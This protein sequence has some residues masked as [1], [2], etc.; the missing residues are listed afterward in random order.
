MQGRLMR[1]AAML[2]VG[3]LA[4]SCMTYDPYTEE[5]KVSNATWGTAIGAAGGAA[6]GAAIGAISGDNKK[7]RRKR[8]LIGAG[9]GA[10]TGG[11]AGGAVGYYMDRQEAQL[12]QRLRGS[13]VSVTRVG[14]E[15]ILNMPGN[16][17]FQTD[18]DEIR[19]QF[20]DTLSSVGL[21]VQE[22]DQTLAVVAGHT[23]STGSDE[24]NARLSVRRAETVAEY[25]ASQGID[26][27]RL[28]PEGYGESRPI[29][30]NASEQGRQQNR[31]VEIT[32]SPLVADS[33]PASPRRR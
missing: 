18:R 20:F 24:H 7:E 26:R 25:L 6:A 29:A 14:D 33:S 11:L 32:L 13:G 31:R 1:V 22:F 12:R 5:E 17:T 2:T 28:L 21:V 27:Q 10:V 19:P 8:A 30:D 16:V 4:T 23:D 3:G 15:I 9:A